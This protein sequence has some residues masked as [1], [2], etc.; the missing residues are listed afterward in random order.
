MDDK[1]VRALD[2]KRGWWKRTFFRWAGFLSALSSQ[3]KR[4]H[5][6]QLRYLENKSL[7]K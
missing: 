5:D 2:P 7:Y 3:D 4:I 1:W 6:P